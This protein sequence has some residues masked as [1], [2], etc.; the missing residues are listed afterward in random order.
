MTFLWRRNWD[1]QSGDDHNVIRDPVTGAFLDRPFPDFDTVRNT[2]NP[3]YTWQQNR[4]I[5]FLYTKNF[6]GALGDQFEL[7]VS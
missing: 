7:L 1:Y 5:S 2:Y 6:A 3:N 4:S